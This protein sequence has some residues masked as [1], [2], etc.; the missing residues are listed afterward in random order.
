MTRGRHTN[1]AH[2][3][4]RSTE[5]VRD[6][7]CQG[8]QFGPHATAVL[9]GDASP[10]APCAELVAD[11]QA[12]ERL[13]QPDVGHDKVVEPGDVALQT[14][15]AYTAERTGDRQKRDLVSDFM[16]TYPPLDE[17]PDASR[18]R[19]ADTCNST[20]MGVRSAAPIICRAP[21]SS[22]PLPSCR[23]CASRFRGP[24]PDDES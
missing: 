21:Y 5:E 17:W 14:L 15:L 13:A 4:Q 18:D 8:E 6:D 12:Q 1:I 9:C 7:R 10:H 22:R 16:L 3:Y 24:T 11:A 19:L 2:F 20:S 23:S